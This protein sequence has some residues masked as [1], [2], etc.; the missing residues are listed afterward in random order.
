MRLR[1]DQEEILELHTLWCCARRKFNT[2]HFPEHE[3][4]CVPQLHTRQMDADTR[5]C[6]SAKGMESSF[7]GRRKRLSWVTFLGRYPAVGIEASVGQSRKQRDVNVRVL[8]SM[9]RSRC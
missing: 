2:P 4:H 5:S 1:R 9:D 7:S 8:T 6:A 3:S